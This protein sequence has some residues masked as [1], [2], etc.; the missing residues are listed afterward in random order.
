[1]D[2]PDVQTYLVVH[3]D[4]RVSQQLQTLASV[5]R[6]VFFAGLPGTGKSLLSH[7]L[8]HLAVT[9]G[10]TVH[11]LQW[12]VARPVFEAH[13]AGQRY[14]VVQGITHAVI[15]KAVGHWARHALV[16]WHHQH[17]EPQHL[18]IGETP[19]V[20]NRFVE[21]V[22]PWDDAAEG[23]LRQPTSLFVLPVPS[24]QV[25]QHIEAERW[26]RSTNPLHPQ[27]QE[28]APPHVLQALWQELVRIA[29]LLDLSS[30][31]H[32]TPVPYDPVLYQGVYQALLRHRQVQVLPVDALLPTAA[33]SVYDFAI[34]RTYLTPCPE[35]VGRFIRGVEQLYPH[36]EALH[37]D[38]VSWYR[39]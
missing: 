30:P 11:L 8:A 23:L 35:E 2:M 37:R 36:P 33:L 39:V 15:R 20:G 22:Q 9:S 13:P 38:I 32:S 17:P 34:E 26:R 12:D 14:P 7:Q 18:L 31:S 19:F 21:L 1:M 27:E 25:R 16:T 10:R 4:A 5:Q 6:F 3:A 29:P 28:D 24:R